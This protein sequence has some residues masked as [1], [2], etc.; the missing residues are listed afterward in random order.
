VEVSGPVEIAP[1][2][3]ST[4]QM[5]SDI[6]EQ[7]LIV[8]T[9]A[10]LTVIT[11]CAHPGIVEMTRKAREVGNG[12]INLVLGGFHLSAASTATIQRV[13][14]G[15]DDLEVARVAP[16]HCTGAY[17]VA[18]L[19]IAFGEGYQRCGVGMVVQEEK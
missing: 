5:G 1:G 15:L 13:A 11:G 4:G 8:Q 16:C 2:L 12:E 14:A 7:A 10:G 6:V 19:A 9:K 3:W 18:Q 17:S